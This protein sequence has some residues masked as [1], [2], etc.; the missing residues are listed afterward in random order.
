M[1]LSLSVRIAEGYSDKK[2]SVLSLE[3]ICENARLSNYK[4][5]CMRPSQVGVE[6]SPEEILKAY[7]I[8][9]NNNLNVSMITGDFDMP[10]NNDLAGMAQRNI[11]PY[12]DLCKLLNSTLI[13]IGIKNQEDVKYTQYACDEAKERGV[14]LVH[15]MHTGTLFETVD[16]S[17]NIVS[18]INRTNFGIVYEPANLELCGQNYGEIAIKKLYPHVFNVYLQNQIVSPEGTNEIDTWTRGKIRF[19]S[20]P[21]WTPSKI[22]FKHIIETLKEL[23]YT[24]FVTI[25]Q[26]SPTQTIN[27]I[28][29]S[30]EYLKNLIG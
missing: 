2:K 10:A 17:L 14:K 12:I 28:K 23:N 6:N 7:E 16:E 24:G 21:I 1:K 25:H 4:A 29:Q 9:A 8:V 11:T 15:Q 18:E 13:R 27:S 26:S 22:N 30:A 19:H 5:I 3:Q 20:V